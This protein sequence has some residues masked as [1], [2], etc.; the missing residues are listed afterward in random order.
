MKVTPLAQRYCSKLGLGGDASA[1]EIREAYFRLAFAHHPDRNPGDVC[2]AARFKEIQAAYEWL[3]QRRTEPPPTAEQFPFLAPERSEAGL[4]WQWLAGLAAV[5]ALAITLTMLLRATTGMRTAVKTESPRSEQRDFLS[6]KRPLGNRPLQRRAAGTPDWLVESSVRSLFETVEWSSPGSFAAALDAVFWGSFSPERP[7]EAGHDFPSWQATIKHGLPPDPRL[8]AKTVSESSTGSTPGENDQQVQFEG[9]MIRFG[10]R[11]REPVSLEPGFVFSS[12]QP[13]AKQLEPGDDIPGKWSGEPHS[14]LLQQP[15]PIE[16]TNPQSSGRGNSGDALHQ[17]KRN[18]HSLGPEVLSITTF[19]SYRGQSNPALPNSNPIVL[20]PLEKL[21]SA[22]ST[23]AW[24]PS[25]L[26]PVQSKERPARQ[27]EKLLGHWPLHE[28]QYARQPA[29]RVQSTAT[30]ELST[31]G[32]DSRQKAWPQSGITNGNVWDSRGSFTQ[33]SIRGVN[34]NFSDSRRGGAMANL[35]W[36]SQQASGTS[37]NYA[38]L[39]T[40]SQERID[41]SFLSPTASQIDHPVHT[42]PSFDQSPWDILGP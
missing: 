25:P 10:N 31:W 2:A 38:G 8:I 7:A 27:E 24:K 16:H 36:N 40:S 18:R 23:G 11:R 26:F 12:L 17:P 4:V 41:E 34:G 39:A 14:A 42:L 35:G 32:A 22:M 33:N 6:S 21:N 20:T 13:T 15:Q 37:S 28:T 9:G 5:A 3:S 1:E 30:A 29:D 19:A